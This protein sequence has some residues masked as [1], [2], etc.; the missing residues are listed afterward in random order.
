VVAHRRGCRRLPHDELARALVP[1]DRRT[2]PTSTSKEGGL[3]EQ[4]EC[5]PMRGQAATGAVRDGRHHDVS[6]SASASTVGHPRST[7]IPATRSAPARSCASV[8]RHPR[9]SSR[10]KR[11]QGRELQGIG[12][13]S[14]T[15]WNG[16]IE[17]GYIGCACPGPGIE[18]PMATRRWGRRLHRHHSGRVRGDGTPGGHDHD[19]VGPRTGRNAARRGRR[20][21]RRPV[22]AAR[23]RPA[24][25]GRPHE[26]SG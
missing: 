9:R 21:R 22:A 26:P 5:W 25:R 23:A 2:D 7:S 12:C 4:P 24:A 10:S 13:G 19:S 17:G 20:A 14:G 18:S 1:L 3:H 6:P 15:G 16:T 11:L 8:V